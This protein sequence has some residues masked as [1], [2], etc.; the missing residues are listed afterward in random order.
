[1]TILSSCSRSLPDIDDIS[2]FADFGTMPSTPLHA[3]AEFLA[4]RAKLDDAL[5]SLELWLIITAHERARTLS[6]AAREQHV[7]FRVHILHYRSLRACDSAGDTAIYARDTLLA[8]VLPPISRS[9]LFTLL[10][11]IGSGRLSQH[12]YI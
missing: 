11:R 4:A 9:N 7:E 3:A 10:C 2:L 12:I 1:M 6:L 8:D 5:F